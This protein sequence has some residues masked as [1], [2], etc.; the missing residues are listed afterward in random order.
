MDRRSYLPV[1]AT[2]AL[3]AALLAGLPAHTAS[4][5]ATST[6]TTSVACDPAFEPHGLIGEAWQSLGGENSIFGCPTGTEHGFVANNTRRQDFENGQISWSPALSST[7]RPSPGS[8]VSSPPPR[9]IGEE[10]LHLQM[11]PFSPFLSDFIFWISGVDGGGVGGDGSRGD[12]VKPSL[13][14]V[15]AKLACLRGDRRA[16]ERAEDFC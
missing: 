2:L 14:C 6:A 9:P 3:S 13:P 8:T 5:T 15:Q 1:T 16:C 10:I 12:V 4:A 7:R 11:A